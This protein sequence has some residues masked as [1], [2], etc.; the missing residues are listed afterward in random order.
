MTCS[1]GPEFEPHIGIGLTLKKIWGAW[2]AQL[3]KCPTLASGSGHGLI[4]REIEPCVRLCADSV[5]P[6]WD[7][8]FLFF[9]PRALPVINKST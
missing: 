5:E 4:V 8:L 6:A 2:V 9:L 1:R 3:V 7:S